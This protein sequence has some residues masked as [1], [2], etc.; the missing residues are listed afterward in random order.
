MFKINRNSFFTGFSPVWAAILLSALYWLYLMPITFPLMVNDSLGYR[1][2]GQRIMSHGVFSYLNG[3]VNREPLYPCFLA[4]AMW[5]G[6]LVRMDYQLVQ[7]VMQ[8]TLLLAT[9]FIMVEVLRWLKINK[10]IIAGTVLY[11][12]FSPA[13]IGAAASGWSE[14][15]TF[16]LGIGVIFILCQFWEAL[17]PDGK[18]RFKLAV[19]AAALCF[20]MCLVK[21]VFEYVAILLVV[22]LFVLA[23]LALDRKRYL[24]PLIV[25][26]LVLFGGI[27]SYKTASYFANG[28]FTLSQQSAFGKY[29]FYASTV[30][31]T[32]PFTMK[33]VKSGLLN[34]TGGSLCD[35][36]DP[37]GCA[38]WKLTVV[39]GIALEKQKELAGRKDKES[40]LGGLIV[41]NLTAHPFR[42][43]ALYGTELIG[44]FFWE[45]S[46]EGF[47]VFPALVVRILKNPFWEVW[48]IYIVGI[49]TLSA[50]ALGAGYCWRRF[51]K[52]SLLQDRAFIFL[53]FSGL[54][55]FSF[56]GGTALIF[57]LK[58]YVYPF[59]PV[60]LVI[61]GWAIQQVF[62]QKA[63]YGSETK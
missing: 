16:P 46:R 39:D 12:G 44:M 18:H 27:L 56:L 50:V 51:S 19:T 14:V 21:S 5:L 24:A 15:L 28:E 61:I 32:R 4:L 25:F 60:Y 57:L 31:K 10:W 35:R 3:G 45:S 38:R 30:S 54:V 43:A 53:V 36:W 1:D 9:Q 33:D 13:V 37:E 26:T 55:V 20:I 22:L 11:F 41:Q 29:A 58:R 7:Y 62:L 23:F 8:F 49:L 47:V 48:I 59:V 17:A 34:A 63:G 6:K 40:V 2:L 42:F 52:V